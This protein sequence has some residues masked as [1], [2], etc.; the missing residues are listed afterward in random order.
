MENIQN[1]FHHKLTNGED[2]NADLCELLMV[3]ETGE[4]GWLKSTLLAP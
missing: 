1:I 2:T 3:A 4:V